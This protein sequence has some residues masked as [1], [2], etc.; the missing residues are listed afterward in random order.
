M[1]H[2][3]N[4]IKKIIFTNIIDDIQKILGA[5]RNPDFH[6]TSDRNRR[7]ILTLKWDP[8]LKNNEISDSVA[9]ALQSLWDDSELQ[10]YLS[11]NKSSYQLNESCG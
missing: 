9:H 8:C 10:I 11:T 3:A 4:G 6:F 2:I 5:L 1:A 7:H